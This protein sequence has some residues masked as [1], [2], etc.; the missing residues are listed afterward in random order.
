MTEPDYPHQICHLCG[1]AHGR[2]SEAVQ[3][4]WQLGTCDICGHVTP[5]TQPR[6]FGHLK[7]SWKVAI[8][9]K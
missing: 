2:Q 8:K 5:V 4:T 6:D 9:N 1:V 3:S 7:P